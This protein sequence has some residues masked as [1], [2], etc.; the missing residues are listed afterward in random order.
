[1]KVRPYYSAGSMSAAFFDLVTAA[2]RSLDGDIA[3]YAGLAAP[4]ARVLELGAGSARIAQALAEQGFSVTGVEIAPAMLAKART[5]IAALPAEVAARIEMRQGDMTALRLD[6]TFDLAIC[7]FFTLAHVPA[8]MAWTNTF[9]GVAAHLVPGGLAAF[10][11]PRLDLMKRPA[12]ADRARPVMDLALDGGRRLRLYIAERSFR[13]AQGRFDQV[14]DYALHDP[15]GRVIERSPE[16]LTFYMADPTP[17]AQAAGLTPD[18]PPIDIG[19]VGDIW[20]FR[21]P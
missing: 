7:P 3:T 17:F 5:R 18:R 16:R 8:G 19:G 4:G 14:V 2:D 1:M 9:A 15:T 20:V 10:H 13:E 12:P 6:Q 11:L 21:K